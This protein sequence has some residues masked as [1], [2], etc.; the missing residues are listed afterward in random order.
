M[1]VSPDG[2]PPW[3]QCSVVTQ[4]E[5]G[6]VRKNVAGDTGKDGVLIALVGGWQQPKTHPIRTDNLLDLWV[7]RSADAGHRPAIVSE[8]LSAILPVQ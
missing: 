7:C 4:H 1:W 8:E 3:S 2:R 6:T 5:P